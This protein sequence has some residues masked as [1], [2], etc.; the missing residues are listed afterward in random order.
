MSERTIDELKRRL[1]LTSRIR[2]TPKAEDDPEVREFFRRQEEDAVRDPI[3]VD[4]LS[5]EV[6]QIQYDSDSGVDLTGI[7][8][9]PERVRDFIEGRGRSYSDVENFDIYD[10]VAE[11]YCTLFKRIRRE[12]N[13]GIPD[14]ITSVDSR[15]VNEI[16]QTIL[17]TRWDEVL[18]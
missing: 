15:L 18:K 8:P 14:G 1:G 17:L 9:P 16:V 5:P 7:V 4:A 11:R 3:P 2:N 10:E 6:R 12:L 13:E